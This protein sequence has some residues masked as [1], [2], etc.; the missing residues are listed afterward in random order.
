M[1][2]WSMLCKHK[3]LSSALWICFTISHVLLH[4]TNIYRPAGKTLIDSAGI[5]L[6]MI[7]TDNGVLLT[8]TV[9][10]DETSDVCT[11]V[12]SSRRKRAATV[13]LNQDLLL[14]IVEDP[15]V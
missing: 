9:Q 4:Y 6:L 7:A 13:Y 2:N 1:R 10:Y 12:A 14:S 3:F 8:V 11:S 5:S 15:A